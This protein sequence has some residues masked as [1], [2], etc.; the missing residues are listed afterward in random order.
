MGVG[1]DLFSRGIKVKYYISSTCSG[2]ATS[3]SLSNQHGCIKSPRDLGLRSFQIEQPPK[4]PGP[5]SRQ[6]KP[7][8]IQKC[9][10]CIDG[11]FACVCYC[12]DG[13]KVSNEDNPSLCPG[14][15][16]YKW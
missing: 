5:G 4:H 2:A 9:G 1:K 13:S 11:P 12:T 10:D 16:D 7:R 14:D 15:W 6:G 3:F 8:P